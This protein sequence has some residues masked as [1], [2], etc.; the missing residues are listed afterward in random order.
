MLA[1]CLSAAMASASASKAHDP[2][3][4]GQP[5]RERPDAAEQVGDQ[6]GVADMAVH[7]P[8]QG[9]FAGRGRLQE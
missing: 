5:K 7:Q 4:L 1:A 8:R 9:L 3:P 6:L 2:G